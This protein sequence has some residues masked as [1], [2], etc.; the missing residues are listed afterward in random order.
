MISYH[1]PR[2]RRIQQGNGV[3]NQRDAARKFAHRLATKMFGR[4]GMCFH[5]TLMEHTSSTL[6]TFEA[7]IGTRR[8]YRQTV[9][10]PVRTVRT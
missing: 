3:R 7:S 8:G 10:I 9:C 6:S 5:I 1:C 2:L 4:T